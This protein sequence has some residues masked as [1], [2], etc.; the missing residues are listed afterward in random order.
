MREK[1]LISD[2]R[3]AAALPVS[4]VGSAINKPRIINAASPLNAGDAAIGNK[5][6]DYVA[7]QLT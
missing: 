1:L 7:A 4:V 5:L 3:K 2:N 6:L